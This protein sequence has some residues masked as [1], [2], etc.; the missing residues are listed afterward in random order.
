MCAQKLPQQCKQEATYII[1]KD[2]QGRKIK[3]KRKDCILLFIS[4][5]YLNSFFRK[6][7]SLLP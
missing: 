7:G 6:A 2:K 5:G 1:K 4:L 3:E